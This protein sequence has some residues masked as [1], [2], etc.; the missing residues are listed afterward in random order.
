VTRPLTILFSSAG[1]RVELMNG[2]RR[3]A[4]ALGLDL[5]AVATDMNP[6]WSAACQTA[7]RAFNVPSCRSPAFI[8][9]ML[10]IVAEESVDLIVPTIDTE[11]L[12]YAEAA[13]QFEAKGCRVMVSAPDVIEVARDKLLTAKRLAE[14]GVPIPKTATPEEVLAAPEAWNGPLM[15]KPRGGSSSVGIRRI[16]QVADMPD[17]AE[18]DNY[19]VQELLDGVEYTVNIF[20]D[21]TGKL[22]TAVPH[23]RI[24]VR[25]G[26]VSKGVTRRHP[27]LEDAAKAL[28]DTLPGMSGALCFQAIV[29]EDGEARIFEINARFGGGF[30]LAHRAG[31]PFS[32]WLLESLAGL[33]SSAGD[34]WRD[35]VVMLRYDAAAFIDSNIGSNFDSGAS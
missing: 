11:L 12:A 27:A 20:I 29:D 14:A 4:A 30:P 35:G 32:A 17:L 33:P 31:A 2:F 23:Q 1:R 10:E 24:E 6:D 3:D 26:E 5:R 25:G 22:V 15:L 8:G 34:R 9:R 16:D 28:A 21:A 18:L 13:A 19:V 7:D